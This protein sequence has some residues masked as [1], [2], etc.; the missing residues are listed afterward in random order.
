MLRTFSPGFFRD[1]FRRNKIICLKKYLFSRDEFIVGV[2]E[3][4]KIKIEK[5]IRSDNLR[6]D[7]I[8]KTF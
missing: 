3:G 5:D 4:M 1:V 2:N 7:R 8:H 6:L